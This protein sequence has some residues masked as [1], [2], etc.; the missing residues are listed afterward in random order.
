[1]KLKLHSQAQSRDWILHW[2]A[3]NYD[4]SY[5]LL[6]FFLSLC[7]FLSG[8][9]WSRCAGCVLNISQWWLILWA[10][11][12]SWVESFWFHRQILQLL[13]TTPKSFFQSFL[14]LLYLS[15]LEP[16]CI[17]GCCQSFS[18][19][20]TLVSSSDLCAACDLWTCQ[21]GFWGVSP[22]HVSVQDTKIASLERNIRDLEDEIQM[23]KANGLLNTEDREEEIKQMEVYKNHSKFMKTKVDTVCS[24][25]CTCT[26]RYPVNIW[27]KNKHYCAV[28]STD[29]PMKREYLMKPVKFAALAFSFI[30]KVSC[31][32][33]LDQLSGK[34][35]KKS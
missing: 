30:S 5:S 32:Q 13:S 1:M 31:W 6:L 15:V 29:K 11:A 25:A 34:N 10:A 18:L 4:K 33:L 14:T 20:W 17:S 12:R 23:L 16:L 3:S 24:Y 2:S 22:L 9:G 27:L 28:L 7:T 19:S 35:T 26:K 8:P 21:S